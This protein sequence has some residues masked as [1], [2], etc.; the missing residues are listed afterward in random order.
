MLSSLISSR[1]LLDCKGKGIMRELSIGQM[2]ELN[3]VSEKALRIYH[4]KG[5]LIPQ[6]IDAQSGYRYYSIEQCATLDMI[7]QLQSLGFTLDKIQDIAQRDSVEYLEQAVSEQLDVVERELREL[8]I[9]KR[10]GEVTLNSCKIFRNRPICDEVMIEK[11]PDRKIIR[12]GLPNPEMKRSDLGGVE[13]L[14][15][16]EITLR[17]V[18]QEMQRRNV[19]LSL[20]RNV[21]CIIHKENL[22]ARDLHIDD[23]FVFVR[24]SYGEL[25]DDA[26]VVEGGQYLTMYCNSLLTEDGAYAELINVGKMLDHAQ[27]KGYEITGDYFGEIIAETPAFHYQGR[28]TFFK[29][30]IPVRKKSA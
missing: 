8:L 3:C 21:G 23:S 9:A 20:F 7:Q 19:S 1:I 10:V 5:L 4:D 13:A 16:W 14:E 12:L 28:D 22:L 6:R 18:K 26:E 27:S 29:L 2:S 15:E 30:H 11:I 24:K 25:F 17:M